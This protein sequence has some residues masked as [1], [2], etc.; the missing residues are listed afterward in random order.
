MVSWLHH[1][2]ESLWIDS[3]ELSSL[4]LNHHVARGGVGYQEPTF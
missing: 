3:P 1:E 2:F 4:D